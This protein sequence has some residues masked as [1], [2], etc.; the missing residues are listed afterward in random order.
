MFPMGVGTTYN[1][2]FNSRSSPYNQWKLGGSFVMTSKYSTSAAHNRTFSALLHRSVL[3]L[4]ALMAIASCATPPPEPPKPREPATSYPMPS[5]DKTVDA[6]SQENRLDAKVVAWNQQI[7]RERGWLFA[8]AELD[9]VDSKLISPK[10]DAFI[11]SQ[12]LWLKGDIEESNRLLGTISADTEEELD[13]LLSERQRRLTESGQPVD[14]ARVALERMAMQESGTGS[15]TSSTV[16][17]LLS[18]AT[19]QRLA[20]ELRRTE[21][22]SDWQ[23]WLSLNR[24]YRQGRPAVLQWLSE[25]PQMRLGTLDLPSGLQTWLESEPPSRIAVLLPLSGRLKAAGQSALGGIVEGIFANYRDAS[26]R[27]ELI[28]IDTEAAETGMAA[29]VKALE[30]GADFVIGPL[31]KERV[32]ELASVDRLPVPVLALNRTSPTNQ[33]SSQTASEWQM[34]SMSLAPED[35]AEQ[36]AHLA[37]SEGLRNPLIIAPDSAWGNRMKGAFSAS[38]RSLGGAVRETALTSPDETDNAAIARGLATLSSESRIKEVERAFEAPVDTQ[39]RRR[40]DVDS[41]IL[42]S[43]T[44]QMA[45]EIRPLLRFHYAGK[46]PVFAPSSIFQSDESITNR[47]LNGIKFVLPPSAVRTPKTDLIPLHALGAD[48]AALVDH[49]SQASST[50][51]TLMFGETGDLSIDSQGNVRRRLKSVV[52]SRGRARSI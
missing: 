33:A 2:A 48:A 39:A 32:A 49:F 11:T 7:A 13:A 34:L 28:T 47:D 15:V 27:P 37:W 16:F 26:L 38:W 44:A 50:R 6:D 35:E 24:A 51:G 19:E 8:L 20:S 10:T 1:A 22:N 41:V 46:L 12:V 17:D 25:N 40:E 31:T 14:A 42:L 36:L 30:S 21:P 18:Q 45:R 4:L 23:T 3:M 5:R 29:Y 43:P 9:A 52:F